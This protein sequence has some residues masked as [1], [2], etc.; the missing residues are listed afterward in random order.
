[1]KRIAFAVSLVI[2]V[3]AV[4]LLAQTAA[5]KPGP[6][7]K[8]LNIWVGDWTLEGESQATPL[9]PARKY[10]GKATV[11]S[12]MDGFFVEWHGQSGDSIW[13]EVDGYD[14]L[15][16]TYF[17]SGF[18]NDGSFNSAT[19]TI[20]GTTAKYS[21]TLI[22]GDKR[23]R[24]RGTAEFG[25]DFMSFVDKEEVSADGQVWMPNFQNKM[26]KIKKEK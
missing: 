14:A 21:G 1:M 6:E 3:L 8:K 23:Y 15:N 13:N 18:S 9:G 19:Y 12:I 2:V 22:L 7:Q 17:W 24:I 25:S 5:P 10:V 26:V 20:D 16:K 11:R 4:A